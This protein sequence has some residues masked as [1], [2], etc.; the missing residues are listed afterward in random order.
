MPFFKKE[1]QNWAK[2]PEAMAEEPNHEFFMR[3]ALSMAELAFEEGEIPVGAVLVCDGKVITKT[4]N[5]TELL[6]D[7]TAH[8]EML[9]ITS[10][11]AHF[12]SKYLKDCILYISLEPCPMCAAALFWAQIKTV[13][14]GA[15]DDKRGAGKYSPS[16]F[17]PKTEL[18]PGIL[19][20]ES[21][22]IIK[23]F[24]KERR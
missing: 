6:H 12:N 15:T 16:L 19:A 3:K 22:I 1:G 18:I 8:A 10:G 14:W 9:A 4:H 24:F 17:H 13:V 11:F 23:Q 20:K 2:F 7:A 21:E 5:Q